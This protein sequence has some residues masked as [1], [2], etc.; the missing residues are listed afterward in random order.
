VTEVEAI[1]NS[2]PLTYFFST[3]LEEV[4][5]PHFLIGRQVLSIPDGAKIMSDPEFDVSPVD[6][7]QRM[8]HLNGLLN[9]FWKRW[10]SEYLLKLRDCHHYNIGNPI[11]RP[12][13]IGDVVLVHDQQ[14]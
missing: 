4:L 13:S 7:T 6:L 8:S 5:T 14:P 2:R 11:A 12:V 1:L 10:K 9:Q 3:D